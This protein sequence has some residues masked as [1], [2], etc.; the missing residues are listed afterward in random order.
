MMVEWWTDG[1]VVGMVNGGVSEW[2][3]KSM[4][5]NVNGRTDGWME[6]LSCV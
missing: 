6:A 3:V 4:D 1:L 2:V 5:E